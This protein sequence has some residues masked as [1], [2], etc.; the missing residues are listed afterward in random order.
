MARASV[1]AKRNRAS[2]CPYCLSSETEMAF[3]AQYFTCWACGTQWTFDSRV[4]WC[5]AEKGENVCGH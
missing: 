1:T 3:D 2:Q 5:P 4:L